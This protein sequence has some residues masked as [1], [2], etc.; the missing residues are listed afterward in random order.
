MKEGR[1]PEGYTAEFKGH[2]QKFR[3]IKDAVYTEPAEPVGIP[4][5]PKMN[6]VPISLYLSIM[7]LDAGTFLR[8][9][10]PLPNPP[11]SF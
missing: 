2:F 4:G 8:P 6:S 1:D 11:L 9:P 10:P 3:C 7:G 5:F